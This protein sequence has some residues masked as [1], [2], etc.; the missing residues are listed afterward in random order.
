MKRLI[1]KTVLAGF[2]PAWRFAAW[3]TRRSPFLA[4]ATIDGVVR[5]PS[6]FSKT[7]GSPPSMTDIQEFVVP[8]SIPKTLAILEIPFVDREMRSQ[9]SLAIHIPA[10]G[11]RCKLIIHSILEIFRHSGR[12]SNVR[13]DGTSGAALRELLSQP[14][15][16]MSGEF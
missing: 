16:F 6:L 5:A 1:E 3:P 2:V 11:F 7:T 4:N 8:K 10:D 9:P 15:A 13:Q 12:A 14:L